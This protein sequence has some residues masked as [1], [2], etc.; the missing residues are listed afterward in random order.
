MIPRQK[1]GQKMNKNVKFWHS[2]KVK[3]RFLI[4]LINLKMEA[5]Q[6]R[7]GVGRQRGTKVREAGECGRGNGRLWPSH[8]TPPPPQKFAPI[9]NFLVRCKG[10]SL[11]G[12]VLLRGWVNTAQI[13]HV[14]LQ[15]GWSEKYFVGLAEA[16][17][18]D[19]TIATIVI[20]SN[21][22]HSSDCAINSLRNSTGAQ[23]LLL[24]VLH[25]NLYIPV[26]KH[27]KLL[28]SPSMTFSQWLPALFVA[29]SVLI[30]NSTFQVEK[31]VAGRKDMLQRLFTENVPSGSVAH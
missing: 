2:L 7:A 14:F 8:P 17:L 15:P 3:P 21:V 29:F 18:L 19:N 22:I 30:L 20:K 6:W 4:L 13:F 9:K 5:T 26:Q 24:H 23:R 11:V 10:C 28:I 12:C 31:F 25:E 1:K 16:F 27:L